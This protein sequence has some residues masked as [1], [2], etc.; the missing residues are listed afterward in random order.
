MPRAGQTLETLATII[1]IPTILFLVMPELPTAVMVA[2]GL[3][4][5]LTFAGLCYAFARTN[6]LPALPWMLGGLF[7]GTFALGALFFVLDQRGQAD[8]AAAL[9]SD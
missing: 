4:M 3:M 8:K 9:H 1:S 5:L 7:F 6:E 2:T